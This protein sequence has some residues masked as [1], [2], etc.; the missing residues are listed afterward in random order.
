[1][2]STMAMERFSPRDT[3]GAERGIAIA[4]ANIVCISDISTSGL[5]AMLISGCTPLYLGRLLLS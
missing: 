3:C 4:Y 5:A 2:S 1:M